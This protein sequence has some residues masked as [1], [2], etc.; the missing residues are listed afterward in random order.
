[1]LLIVE[2]ISVG[3]INK[4]EVDEF[5]L[6][7]KQLR[8]LELNM[9]NLNLVMKHYDIDHREIVMAQALLET[10]HFQ[11]KLCRQHGNLFGL[12]NS[13]RG[14]FYEFGHWSD[15]VRAYKQ[16]IQRRYTKG[17]YYAFLKRIKYA[18]DPEYIPKLRNIVKRDNLKSKTT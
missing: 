6:S 3:T 12:Y 10:G 17:D 5:K 14:K 4:T 2:A 18:E 1:M 9:A 11:S 7:E 13:K 16:W 15:S 8:K